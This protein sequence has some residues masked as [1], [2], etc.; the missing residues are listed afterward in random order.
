MRPSSSR[1]AAPP[2][3][4][5]SLRSPVHRQRGPLE[6]PVKVLVLGGTGEA[7]RLA[8]ALDGEAGFEVV[9]SLAGRLRAPVMPVGEA[10]VGGFG[11]PDGL[12]AW[13]RGEHVEAVVDATHPFAA[14]ITDSAVIA[15]G[16]AAVPLLVL[17]RPGWS[18]R[19]GDD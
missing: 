15:C 1:T 2:V 16:R 17:R 4:V 10:R 11:G 14:N 12:T 18:A 13:L 5:R 9:S 19:P 7:R 6:R 8:A 3:Y